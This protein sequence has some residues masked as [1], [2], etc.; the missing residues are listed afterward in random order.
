M[1]TT[2]K[3]TEKDQGQKI[4]VSIALPLKPSTCLGLCPGRRLYLVTCRK[5]VIRSGTFTYAPIG[6]IPVNKCTTSC[7][8]LQKMKLTICLERLYE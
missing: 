3:V 1:G 6:Q 2:K 7:I 8:A 5:F 4:T